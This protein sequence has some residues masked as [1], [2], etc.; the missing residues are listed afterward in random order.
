MTSASSRI[1]KPRNKCR[2]KKQG[3]GQMPGKIN[4]LK[5]Q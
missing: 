2:E 1:G 5:S 3:N 4:T